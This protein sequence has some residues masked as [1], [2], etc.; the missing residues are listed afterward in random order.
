MPPTFTAGSGKLGTPCARMH[1]AHFKAL[2]ETS[3]F[4]AAV[5]GVLGSRCSQALLADRY[6]GEL[7]CPGQRRFSEAVPAL[8]GYGR[9][10][11][12]RARIQV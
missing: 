9:E 5:I 3:R 8:K 1:A 10:D 2:L 11:A 12:F 7:G 6:W 4:R